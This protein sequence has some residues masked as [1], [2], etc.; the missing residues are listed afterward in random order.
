MLHSTLYQVLQLFSSQRNKLA[1]DRFL[2]I[3]GKAFAGRPIVTQRFELTQLAKML[4][5]YAALLLRKQPRSQKHSPSHGW[6]LYKHG[7]DLPWVHPFWSPGEHRCK[8]FAC[9]S[10]ASHTP[11]PD[12]QSLA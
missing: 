3:P 12:A 11:S 2:A 9:A 7:E 5:S 8:Q 6:P 4:S 10:Q 1:T